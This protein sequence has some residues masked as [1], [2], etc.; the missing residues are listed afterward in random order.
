VPGL[1]VE[2]HGEGEEGGPGRGAQLPDRL[3]A[4][5]VEAPAF[6]WRDRG[7]FYP[8]SESA[9]GAYRRDEIGME[10]GV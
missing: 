6:V 10:L 4:V 9:I 7:V 5:R 1:G 8:K 3:V 2:G